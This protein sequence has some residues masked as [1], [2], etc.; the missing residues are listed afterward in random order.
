MQI[1]RQTEYAIRTLLELATA[2]EGHLVSAKTISER[3]DVPEGFLLKTIQLLARAGFVVTQRGIQ[4]GVRL[5]RPADKITI[6]D[7]LTVVEGPLALNVC[8]SPGFQCTNQP[9]CRVHQIL[10]R[11]QHALVEELSKETL[12]DI[13]AMAGEEVVKL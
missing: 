9:T 1:T 8:M 11:A 12:A 6:A 13:A 7:V 3:Q 5:A 2:P 10:S 4:G